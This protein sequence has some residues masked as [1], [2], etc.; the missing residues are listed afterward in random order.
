MVERSTLLRFVIERL[1]TDPFR[2]FLRRPELD[3][4]KVLRNAV[5]SGG[6]FQE[7]FRRSV[8]FQVGMQKV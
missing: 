7:R 3:G 6:P 8:V 4:H 5:F 1:P 2:W